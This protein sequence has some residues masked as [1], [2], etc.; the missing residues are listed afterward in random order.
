MIYAI[1]D[2]HGR[3]DLLVKT[4]NTIHQID[5]PD[6]TVVFLGDY[7]DRGPESADVIDRLMEL[8]ARPGNMKVV[9]LMGN[10]ERMMLDALENGNGYGYMSSWLMNGGLETLESYGAASSDGVVSNAPLHHI[11]ISHIKWMKNLPLY[12]ET[13]NYFFVHAGINPD[14]ALDNQKEKDLL[15]IREYFLKTDRGT[16]Q[17]KHVVHGHTPQEY[18]TAR[19][20]HKHRRTNLDSGSVWTNVQTIGIFN[21]TKGG[22]PVGYIFLEGSHDQ[23]T[24]KEYELNV[25]TD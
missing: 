13:D 1:G 20:A 12:Y 24:V 25:E 10:H 9:C 4:L 11:P 22:E 19:F 8:E 18:D 14:R 21:E 17:E 15:W 23:I 5:D 6:K 3:F 16:C 7:V 2:I